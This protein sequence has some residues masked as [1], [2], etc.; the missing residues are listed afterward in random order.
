MGRLTTARHTT[1]VSP[2]SEKYTMKAGRLNSC[3][4]SCREWVGSG[5]MPKM[6]MRT[7]PPA[8]RRVPI[9]IHAENTSPSRRRA[10]KAFQRRETAPSGARMTT[11][12]AAIWNTEPKRLED[13]KMPVE[14]DQRYAMYSKI[15]NTYQSLATIVCVPVRMYDG[16]KAY[17]THGLRC[18]T[19]CCSSGNA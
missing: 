11:G 10:K 8:M 12:S 1:T 7:A 19:L 6:A 5:T 18:S 3:S 15:V 14:T 16:L 17:A 2:K 9:S 13:M 4:K